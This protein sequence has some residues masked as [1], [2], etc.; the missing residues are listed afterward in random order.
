MEEANEKI[1]DQKFWDSH[2]RNHHMP[3]DLGVLSPSIKA[4]IDSLQDKGI[5]ILI[6]GCGNAYEAQY[7]IDQ[8]FC[9][10][11][12]ID[13][14]P[15]LVEKL[16]NKYEGQSNISIIHGDFFEHQSLY[17]LILEQTFFCALPPRLRHK[18]VL[19]MQ[20]LLAEGGIIAG[21]LF[22]RSFEEGP[23]FG[24]S[25]KEYEELFGTSFE[26]LK[27]ENCQ[28]STAKRMGSELFIEFRKS[29]LLL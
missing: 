9:D 11:T 25:K 22:N 27:I 7:L 18:Y 4:Y 2:Y 1:L 26:I 10:I 6:P 19:K 24:G 29:T 8:G 15:L 13:I 28:N 17:D 12:L 16:K 23:P 20:M 5:R 21:V 3:W 14:S